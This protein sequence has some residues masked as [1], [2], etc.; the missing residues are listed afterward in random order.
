MKFNWSADVINA[1]QQAA[2]LKERF[3]VNPKLVDKDFIFN[4]LVYASQENVEAAYEHYILHGQRDAQHVKETVEAFLSPSEARRAAGPVRFLDFASGY[5]RVTR[6][7]RNVAPDWDVTAADIHWAA[8]RF[9]EKEL[10]IK[11]HLSSYFPFALAIPPASFD[12]VFCLSFFSH[13]RDRQFASWLR[14]LLRLVRKDG[15]LII[16][17]HGETSKPLIEGM[18]VNE[19]GYGMVRMS[20]QFDIPTQFYVHACTMP[21]YVEGRLAKAGG[22]VIESFQPGAWFGHQDLY[23]IRR[24]QPEGV[25]GRLK[26]RLPVF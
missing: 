3:H 24:V 16:T 26:E 1:S 19:E 7:F 23:I 14:A 6:H 10:G 21:S 15:I 18:T 25:V 22:G 20:E 12:A 4:A 11:T 2:D 9:N 8:K 5:G 13:V 17:T